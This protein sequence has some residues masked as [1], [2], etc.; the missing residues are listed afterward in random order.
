MPHYA[1]SPGTLIDTL[2]HCAA[3]AVFGVLLCLFFLDWRR[4][5]RRRSWISA[6]TAALVLLWHV[7]AL[8][9]VAPGFQESYT[10]YLFHIF[11]FAGVSLVPAL[12]LHIWL[13]QRYPP[14]W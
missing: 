6:C 1:H 4:S 2:A 12:L 8:L 10:V 3:I 5:C 14:L 11:S 9:I 7:G 13:E